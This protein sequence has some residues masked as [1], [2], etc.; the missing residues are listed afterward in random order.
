MS[1]HATYFRPD[2]LPGVEALRARFEGYSGGEIADA[3]VISEKTVD[4][5][6]ANISSK[7]GLSDRVQITRYAIRRGLIE[8]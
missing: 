4:R 5:H 8:P 3:L 6:R 7:L 1:E 2:G